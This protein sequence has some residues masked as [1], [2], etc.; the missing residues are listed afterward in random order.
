MF[1][2]FLA[3]LPSILICQGQD[4]EKVTITSDETLWIAQGPDMIQLGPQ[5]TQDIEQTRERVRKVCTCLVSIL[6][7]ELCLF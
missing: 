4:K 2:I 6:Y 5:R 7:T 3:M 1:K